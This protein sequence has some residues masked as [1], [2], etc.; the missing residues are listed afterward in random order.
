M[1]KPRRRSNPMILPASQT[2][3]LALLIIALICWGSWANTL[4]LAGK[5]RFEL[6]YY[7]FALGF[8]VLAVVAAFT[9]GSLNSGELTFQDNFLITGYR[10]MAYVI[11]A[12]VV[13]NLGNMLLAAT[14]AVSGMALAFTVTFATALVVATTW[15]FVFEATTGFLVPLCGAG[16]LLAALVMGAAAYSNY[17]IARS[18]A[19]KE[20]AK[21]EA[22]KKDVSQPGGR[23]KRT[24]STRSRGLI[25]ALTLGV[26][27]GIA[28]GLFRPLLDV[29]SQGDGGVAPY[30]AALLFAVGVLVSTVILNPFFLNF[31]V[32]GDPIGFVDYFKGTGKQHALGFLGGVIA[33][34][35]FLAGMLA[36][37]APLAIRTAAMPSYALSQGAPVLAV[38][39]GL[40]V[41]REFKSAGQRSKLLFQFMWVLLAIGI[42]LLALARR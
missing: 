31:P 20:A 22:A 3:T 12:G 2:A 11:A 25:L 6:Y 39:W 17:L 16:L 32:A 13:F 23:S 36:L 42:G 26:A 40:L 27:G 34:V 41:W 37:N 33:G 14:I 7:D 35:A 15:S 18:E 8:A 21:S 1:Q 28:L 24:K 19:A 9:G 29:G 10:N 30:G 4:K 38:A 5:W